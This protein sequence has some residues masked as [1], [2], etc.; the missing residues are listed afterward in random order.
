GHRPSRCRDGAARVRTGTRGRGRHRKEDDFDVIDD[1]L[2]LG[3]WRASC[4]TN[5][6]AYAL[7]VGASTPTP[8]CPN[9]RPNWLRARARGRTLVSL[10]G[11]INRYQQHVIEYLVEENRVLREQLTFSKRYRAASSGDR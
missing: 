4:D 5:R 10:A 9:I 7:A 6:S 11:W 8:S 2:A 3:C 1:A